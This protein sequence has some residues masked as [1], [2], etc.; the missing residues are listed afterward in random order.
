MRGVGEP[1]GGGIP[2]NRQHLARQIAWR[3][4]VQAQGDLSECARRRAL[5]IANDA[6]LK[7]QVPGLAG[8]PSHTWRLPGADIV[9]F[10]QE[11][12][13]LEEHVRI[14]RLA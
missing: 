5:E 12:F 14:R 9:H 7:K 13:G 2:I 4:Q 3:L 6:D 10:V 8:H 1:A 11:R